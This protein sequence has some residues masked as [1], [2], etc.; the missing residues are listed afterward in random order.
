MLVWL[1]VHVQ[2]RIVERRCSLGAIDRETLSSF[3][4]SMKL[5]R[6]GAGRLTRAMA[7]FLY[8]LVTGRRPFAEGSNSDVLAADPLGV[9]LYGYRS[10][11]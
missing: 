5:N 6:D 4:S 9:V 2:D 8:D 10:A 1:N 11:R 7:W 3:F